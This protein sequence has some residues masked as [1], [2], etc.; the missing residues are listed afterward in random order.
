MKLEKTIQK[1]VRGH[2]VPRVVPV[3]DMLAGSLSRKKNVTFFTPR[4]V[5]LDGVAME[6]SEA[7]RY[8]AGIGITIRDSIDYLRSLDRG[9]A[10]T[11]Y[12]MAHIEKPWDH[13]IEDPC[14]LDLI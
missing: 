2:L 13:L 8:L 4:Y 11:S 9:I 3:Q 1:V 10:S 12:H 6:I 14:V 5:I 7:F